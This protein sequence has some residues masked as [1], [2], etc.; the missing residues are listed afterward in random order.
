VAVVEVVVL[1]TQCLGM[2][3][4]EGEYEEVEWV[5]EHNDDLQKDEGRLKFVLEQEELKVQKV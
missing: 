1:R 2:V 4:E 5:V 3:V